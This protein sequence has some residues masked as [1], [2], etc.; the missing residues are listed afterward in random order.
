M[1]I[2]IKKQSTNEQFKFKNNNKLPVFVSSA[3][4]G[5]KVFLNFTDY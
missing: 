5:P 4:D 3:H 2:S 1:K